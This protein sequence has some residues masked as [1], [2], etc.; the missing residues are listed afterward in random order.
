[1]ACKTQINCLFALNFYFSQAN[2]L[3]I[4]FFY[5]N[6]HPGRIK[7]SCLS[8]SSKLITCTKQS[9]NTES[10]FFW[11][12]NVFVSKTKKIIKHTFFD[13]TIQS[14]FGV[15]MLFAI[16]WLFKSFPLAWENHL[17]FF[18]DV[19][20]TFSITTFPSLTNNFLN[21]MLERKFK[22][23]FVEKCFTFLKSLF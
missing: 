19:C 14:F 15:S 10:N 12:F 9:K 22:R 1:M 16:I 21:T 3:L 2:T 5:G 8:F 4:S 7:L 11:F 23:K 18:M 6:K 13:T 17:K 20:S